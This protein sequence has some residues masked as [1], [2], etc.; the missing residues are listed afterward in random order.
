MTLYRQGRIDLYPALQVSRGK[1]K[2]LEYEDVYPR[3]KTGLGGLYFSNGS[4]SSVFRKDLSQ[5]T[6]MMIINPQT[7]MADVKT[8]IK[9]PE[10][11]FP[12][13]TN[14][15]GSMLMFK[16]YVEIVVDLCGKLGE[17]RF[18][19]RLTSQEPTFTDGAENTSRHESDWANHILDTVQL[20]RTKS[21]VDITFPII[22]GT[23]DSVRATP[24]WPEEPVAAERV[25]DERDPASDFNEEEQG[26]Y[27][28]N[29]NLYHY[30]G[31]YDGA[32][33][34]PPDGEPDTDHVR[35]ATTLIPPPLDQDEPVDEKERLRRQEA[36]LLPSQPP[37]EGESSSSAAALAPSAPYIDGE[38]GLYGYRG[39]HDGET[40]PA[41]PHVGPSTMSARSFDTIVP[42]TDSSALPPVFDGDQARSPQDDKH[43]MERQRLMAQA[44]APPVEDEADFTGP[45]N[46]PDQDFAP[47]A[48]VINEEEDYNSHTL[49]HNDHTGEHLPQ[50]QR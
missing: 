3:S 26:H 45:S 38:S 50:Y 32:Y 47:S 12:T 29:G 20:R 23:T 9:V 46:P 17:T 5:S 1:N 19:P 41:I 28:E 43:D 15:P 39:P 42:E 18:L 22:V 27:D 48:P 10:G 34:Q 31:G 37:E 30:E 13:M 49:H 14:V 7:L 24:S 33:D 11:A 6:A 40:S 16:Y 21:V 8:S 36:L 4:P 2:K 35:P 44:S 25:A